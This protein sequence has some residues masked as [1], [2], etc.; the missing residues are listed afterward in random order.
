[1]G[2]HD[3]LSITQIC[4]QDIE[5]LVK[6]FTFPWDTPEKTREKW[7]QYFDGHQ[8]KSRTVAIVKFHN[9][10]A[11]YGS[12]IY[13]SECP[14]FVNIPEIGDVWI[15]ES[16]RGM[17]CGTAL[18]QWLEAHA[19][20]LG[21]N[22]IGIGVGL[23]ADYGNAQKLYVKLGYTPDG[24]GVTYQCKKTVPGNSYPLDDDL[25]L[26]LKKPLV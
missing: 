10:I 21:Y 2:T 11:G 9:K 7:G 18:I 16:H 24:N 20:K 4:Y 26:W 15:D 22:E 1:M 3:D 23:Y 12:L 25:I 13:Q 19:K 5:D 14:F 17:G 6:N 8:K